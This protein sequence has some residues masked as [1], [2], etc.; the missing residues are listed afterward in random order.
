[1]SITKIILIIVVSGVLIF[2]GMLVYLF[3]P[4]I[5]NVSGYPSLKELRNKPLTLKHESAIYLLDKGNYRFEPYALLPDPNIGYEKKFDLPAGSDIT[6]KE[7][8]TYKSN[9]GSG[10]TDLFVL[11]EFVTPSGERIN[12][13]YIWGNIDSLSG[14]DSFLPK[15][16]W[17]D[18]TEIFIR[19]EK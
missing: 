10:F 16:V 3:I 5:K 1:V 11:G 4:T 13:E 2:I 9:I 7:F 14:E 12:F 19:F 15:A 8:K 18:S 6:L 17:Q